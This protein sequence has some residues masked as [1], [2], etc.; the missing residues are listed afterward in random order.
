MALLKFYCAEG[1]KKISHI[2]QNFHAKLR[3]ERDKITL[4]LL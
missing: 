4:K 1:A 2:Y 3:L